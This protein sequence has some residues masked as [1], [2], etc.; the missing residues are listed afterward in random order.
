MIKNK[1]VDIKNI[2][3]TYLKLLKIF[4]VFNK[5]LFYKILKKSFLKMILG[6]QCS[7]KFSKKVI[8]QAEVSAI[9]HP[10]MESGI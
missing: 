10:R 5:F 3:K 2:L 8:T 9:L 7:Q 6:Y 1:I 4:Y